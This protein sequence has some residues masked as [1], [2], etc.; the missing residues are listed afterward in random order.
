[1][2]APFVFENSY[3]FAMALWRATGRDG[4]FSG[5]LGRAQDGPRRVLLG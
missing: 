4:P 2:F 3:L 5:M 1:M